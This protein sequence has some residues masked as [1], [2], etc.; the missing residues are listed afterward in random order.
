M[1]AFGY[2]AALAAL[3]LLAAGESARAAVSGLQLVA[4]GVTFP[5]YVTHAPGDR[6]RLFIVENGAPEGDDT[7]ALI[8][9]LNLK[10]GVLDPT[11]FVT[12]TGINSLSEG[13]L[14]GMAFHPD[15]FSTDPLNPGR[16]KF[17][18]NLTANDSDPDTPFS[19]YI[20]EYS[21]SANPTVANTGFKPVLDFAQPQMNHNGGWIGFGPND[22]YLYIMTGDGGFGYD[23]GAGHSSLPDAPGNAQ[24][25][26]NNF[27]G[28]VLRVDVNGDDFPGTT[29]EALGE[30]LCDPSH[31]PVCR[32]DGRR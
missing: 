32:Q 11:P 28:K 31:E 21:V 8:R 22:G 9:I 24:D 6:D 12:I 4:S 16:G 1:R 19:T 10:T 23:S 25:L 27:L 14:L 26:T 20:R 15:Y 13:G 2:P 5:I 7:S 29:P 17:Y 30:K 18:V 3:V